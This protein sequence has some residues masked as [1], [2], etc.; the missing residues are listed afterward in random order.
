LVRHG[1]FLVNDKKMNIPSLLLKAGDVITIKESS[2]SSPKI[3]ENI[4][5]AAGRTI[6]EWLESNPTAHSGKVKTLPTR[7]QIDIPV[8]EHLIVELYSR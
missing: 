8:Q 1:H 6:P 3:K 2:L 7:E 5:G 4:E